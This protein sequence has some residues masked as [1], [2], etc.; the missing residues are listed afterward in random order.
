MYHIL[1]NVL[2][3]RDV[4]MMSECVTT[5]FEPCGELSFIGPLMFKAIAQYLHLG[6]CGPFTVSRIR[7]RITQKM[8]SYSYDMESY[9]LFIPKHRNTY[10]FYS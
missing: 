1:Q 7:V 4:R 5:S 8:Y 3:F 10:F 6:Q 2:F 9:C